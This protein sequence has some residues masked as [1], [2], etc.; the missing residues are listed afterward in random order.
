MPQKRTKGNPEALM[1]IL[2]VLASRLRKA[3]NILEQAEGQ[4]TLIQSVPA[5]G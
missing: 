4:K 1:P 5:E 3:L 2:K